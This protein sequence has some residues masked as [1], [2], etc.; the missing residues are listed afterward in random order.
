MDKKAQRGCEVLLHSAAATEKGEKVLVITDD[1]SKQIGEEMYKCASAYTDT[2]LAC[3]KPTGSHGAE[4]TKAIAV[5]MEEADVIFSATTFS[6][7]NTEARVNAC[8]KES[9]FVNMADYSLDMLEQGSLFVDFDQ[10]VKMTDKIADHITGKEVVLTT[11]AGTHL[12]CNIEG[13]EPLRCY[14]IADKKGMASA[15]P[16][17]E[18]AIGPNVGSAQGVI[19]GDAAVPLPG[20]G[21]VKEKIICTVENGYITKVEGGKEA[22][23]LR[24]TFASFN[25]ERVYLVAEIGC[26]TNTGSKVSGRMLVDE[27]VYGTIHMGI[28]N[29]VSFGGDNRAPSHI[30]LVMYQPTLEIDGKV[31]YESGEFVVEEESV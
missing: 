14:G 9:R 27:G 21:I 6:L 11:P 12:T 20:I 22:T 18:A 3:M 13:R 28:G 4:P 29:N 25:D 16:I 30:D 19:V 8:A 24:D 23:I 2:T 5:A 1:H 17:F 15:P 26:G 7:F 31:I 10:L